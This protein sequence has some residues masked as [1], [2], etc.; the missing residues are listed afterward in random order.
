MIPTIE[1]L[2]QELSRHQGGPHQRRVDPAHPHDLYADFESPN[3]VGLVAVT[4]VK[5]ASLRPLRALTLDV[6]SRSDGRWS[7]R[8]ALTEPLLRPVFA[9]L[10]EDI[11]SFTRGG[12]NAADLPTA[13][14]SRIERWR[15]LLERGQSGLD[16]STLRGLMGELLVLDRHILEMLPPEEALNTWRG[17]MGAP[18]DFLLPNG[19]RI[20]VKAIG[21]AAK[22]VQIHGLDQLDPGADQL[23]LAIVRVASTGVA[24]PG[25]VSVPKLIDQLRAR[26]MAH[27]VALDL[28]AKRLAEVGWHDHPSHHE[29][30]MYLLSIEIRNVDAT[31]PRL[32]SS[33]VPAG[34]VGADYTVILPDACVV[35]WKS[36]L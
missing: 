7:L 2:W 36:E 8:I 32:I 24:A 20:E 18:Q 10:C 14:L 34:V 21:R 6:G 23:T 29:Y 17:P 31:F 22:T 25:S 9:A 5:P 35:I 16:E 13:V 12:V 1:E 27:P 4:V 33:S 11:V 30:S 28:F 19:S 3:T 26:L 15:T